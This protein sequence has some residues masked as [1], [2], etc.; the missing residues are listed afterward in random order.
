MKTKIISIVLLFL[1]YSVYGQIS[2]NEKPV[3]LKLGL[4][5]KN[6]RNA[7][8]LQQ[9]KQPNIRKLQ[10]EDEKEEEKGVPPRFGYLNKV[11]FN[12]SN[13]GEWITL[14]NGDKLW[15]LN[16]HSKGALSLNLLY[17][18]FWLP[19]GGK[20]FIYSKDG[21][22]SIGAFTARNNN[23]KRNESKGFA[24]GLVYSDDII[25]E[26][27][28]PAQVKEKAIISIA[29]VVYGYRYINVPN[30][31]GFGDAGGCHIN[32]N[33]T[34]GQNWQKEKEAVALILVN[35]NRYCTGSL[36]N[37]TAQDL[38]PLL[39]TAN[40]CLGGE[41]NNN[42]KYDAISNPNLPHYSFYWHY[43][44]PTCSN[45]NIE[46][47]RYSTVGATIKANN[48]VSDFALLELT[49]DPRDLN[50][51][52]P[53]YLGWDR[54][55][56]SFM[57]A[58]GIHHPRV[59]VKKISIENHFVKETS[60]YN[61]S[62]STHWKVIWDKGVTEKGSSGSPLFNL[63]KRVVGQLHGGRATCEVYFKDEEWYG[64]KEPDWYGC[65]HV[66]WTG[67][68]NSDKRRRLKDWLDPDGTGASVLDGTDGISILGSNLI[69][70][71]KNY[72]LNNLPYEMNIQWSTSNN[73][74]KLI[75]GQG[76][77]TATFKKKGNGK[78]KIFAALPN[79][80][81]LERE[82]IVG[83]PL[84]S[85]ITVFIN[86]DAMRKAP[87]VNFREFDFPTT[88]AKSNLPVLCTSKDN[89]LYATHAIIE[90]DPDILEDPAFEW[91][92]KEGSDEWTLDVDYFNS[93]GLCFHSMAVA[94]YTPSYIPPGGVPI[95]PPV[96]EVRFCDDCGCSEWKEISNFELKS[97]GLYDYSLLL[98]P[99]GDG[100]NDTLEIGNPKKSVRSSKSKA[101]VYNLTIFT[102]KGESVYQK[103]RY[104]Q[105]NE[106]FIGIGNVGNY[107]NKALPAGA[108]FFTIKGSA[109]SSGHI[110]IKRDK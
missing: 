4:N 84:A 38:R 51:F 57:G 62:G 74:L 9:I 64:P 39:L 42:Y 107:A 2:T 37:T 26:Y 60:Y 80:N 72:T 82:V 89:V 103:Q 104:M 13:S 91:R 56:S 48:S 78:C 47:P 11:N 23:G 28:Q 6:M 70:N 69:C 101:P 27:Y 106:R 19:K 31:R 95:E 77:G 18:K 49:E 109:N 105:D 90:N 3:G 71:Q 108:Y 41:Y 34:E 58:V 83:K 22:H 86:D 87:Q 16:I 66:S 99:N 36:I 20:L 76:S 96:F 110:Y 59:D 85:D 14:K 15:R 61:Y 102:K 54:T 40:H 52:I 21:K 65:F 7:Q 30:N 17:D 1:T 24:T 100:V 29:Y 67:N 81:I 45:S 25:V 73:N 46:P 88:R 50:V 35:G 8:A 32:I 75:A 55:G 93:W 92:I 43:E 12:L 10:A 33:C 5:V 44:H 63:D 53:Y 97:C 79:T 98:T 94:K 68:N